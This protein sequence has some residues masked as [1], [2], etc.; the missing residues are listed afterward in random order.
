MPSAV[1]TMPSMTSPVGAGLALRLAAVA[2]AVQRV[3]AIGV[4]VEAVPSSWR[5]V[6]VMAQGAAPADAAVPAAEWLAADHASGAAASATASVSA[7]LPVP[8]PFAAAVAVAV[9]PP[10]A[11]APPVARPGRRGAP[12]RSV[13]SGPP[14][15]P[16]VRTAPDAPV[17]IPSDAIPVMEPKATAP[18][19]IAIGV[20]P[21]PAAT[22]AID[23][24]PEIADAAI[25]I[26]LEPAAAIDEAVTERVEIAA[27]V[28]SHPVALPFVRPDKPRVIDPGHSPAVER[29]S[30]TLAQRI[31]DDA[32]RLA[33]MRLEALGWRIVGRNLRL[34]RVEIDLLAIDPAEPAS[35]VIVEVRRR[36]RRD[37]G[38]AEETVDFRK[39]AALRRAAGELAIRPW[40]PDGRRLPDL[41]V[42]VDLVAI[43][44]GPDGRPSLRHHRGIEL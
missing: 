37:F 33:A 16:R 44:R 2:T 6:G 13:K 18:E 31:G 41:P 24:A 34:S 17:A 20:A 15:A 10:A 36:T 32:E 7:S 14:K 40:L 11:V 8:A 28:A 25:T 1:A 5:P 22:A 35:L 39:R 27:L 19:P 30:S 29:A 42:R 9:A 12:A 3:R 26:A 21:G 4:P 43:D 38:L 23:V